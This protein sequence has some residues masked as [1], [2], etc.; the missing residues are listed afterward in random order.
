MTLKERYQIVDDIELIKV[1]ESRSDYTD[2]CVLVVLDG[3]Q[4]FQM[5]LNGFGGL[6]GAWEG[7]GGF[8]RGWNG[9]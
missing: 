5:V 1:L 8:R 9:F 7:W 6:G 3:F 2:E 4:S